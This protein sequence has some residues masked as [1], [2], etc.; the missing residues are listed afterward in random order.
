M[1]HPPGAIAHFSVELC[2][3][4]SAGEE[5]KTPRG[6][7]EKH[8]ARTEK[9]GKKKKTER[10]WKK[11][12]CGRREGI[13]D[14]RAQCFGCQGCCPWP[15]ARALSQ[16]GWP[17]E[18]IFNRGVSEQGRR[19]QAWRAVSSIWPPLPPRA[20][21]RLTCSSCSVVAGRPKA[22]PIA[23]TAASRWVPRCSPPVGRS[24]PVS[25]SWQPSPRVLGSFLQPWG[26][27]R[28]WH[29]VLLVPPPLP[30]HLLAAANPEC[31][32]DRGGGG[33]TGKK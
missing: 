26:V 7:W 4:F 29:G 27:K 2:N 11:C 18:E 22:A 14:P 13:W 15:R 30:S 10:N 6:W 31:A 20:S 9:G 24:S 5:K 3:Q 32:K 16:R 12:G 1:L 33:N 21:P 23:P 25:W 28:G 8:F 17:G 19:A